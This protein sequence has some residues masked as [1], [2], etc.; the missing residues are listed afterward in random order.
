MMQGQHSPKTP[1]KTLNDHDSHLSSIN[2]N[3]DPMYAPTKQGGNSIINDNSS[4]AQMSNKFRNAK[5]ANY[6][7]D[8]VFSSLKP[9]VGSIN[10]FMPPNLSQYTSDGI[11]AD[12][13]SGLMNTTNV[14]VLN[15]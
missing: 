12:Y 1:I 4:I 13:A 7:S 14:Q 5:M 8:N 2:Q 6:T 15:P 3:L 9:A 10:Q 11:L